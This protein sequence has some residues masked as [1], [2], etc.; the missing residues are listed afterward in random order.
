MRTTSSTWSRAH[1]TKWVPC[2]S[3]LLPEET[4]AQLPFSRLAGYSVTEGGSAGDD[5]IGPTGREPPSAFG[6]SPARG[7][8]GSCA[9]VSARGERAELEVTH[10]S[11][12]GGAGNAG[13][14]SAG[15]T[16]TPGLNGPI[17]AIVPI[18]T[19]V[20]LGTSELV[21]CFTSMTLAGRPVD[22]YCGDCYP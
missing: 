2:K 18:S 15:M 8:K 6:I 14:A 16:G 12:Q 20:E 11:L 10:L 19:L 21:L 22:I 13:A 5:Q 1:S 4:D 9:S 3:S 7:E 17:L